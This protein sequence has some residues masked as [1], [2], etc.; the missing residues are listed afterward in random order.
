MDEFLKQLAVRSA[1]NGAGFTSLEFVISL[2]LSFALAMVVGLV[3]RRTHSGVSYSRSF[4]VTMILMAVTISFIM[5]IIGSNL[6]RAFSLVGALSIIRYRNAVRE[7][8]DTAFIFLSMAVGMACG[9]RLYWFAIIFTGMASGMVLLLDRI[10]FGTIRREERLVRV[11]L[12]DDSDRTSEL[13]RTLRRLAGGHCSLLSSEV[14]GG[15]LILTYSVELERETAAAEFLKKI[16]AE[17]T[18]ADV[19]MLTGFETFNI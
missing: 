11:A 12:P 2:L 18:G 17:H 6:A 7:S 4:S 15:R 19:K 9:V 13:E 1:E 5:L 14:L 8:R 3:Y 10:Q 16:A